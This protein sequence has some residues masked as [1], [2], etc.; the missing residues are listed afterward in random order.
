VSSAADLSWLHSQ[1]A[2]V[3]VARAVTLPRGT[4]VMHLEQ[5]RQQL[6]AEVERFLSAPLRSHGTHANYFL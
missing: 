4:H 5:G 6:Y 1:L 2:H 3:L